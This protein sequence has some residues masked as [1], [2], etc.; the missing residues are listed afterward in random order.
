MLIASGFGLFAPLSFLEFLGIS[1]WRIEGKAYLGSFFIISAAVVV[2]HYGAIPVR[3]LWEKYLGVCT[4]WTLHAR[5]KS[6]TPDEQERLAR[7]L[8]ENTRTQKFSVEDGTVAGLVHAK[9]IYRAVSAADYYAVPF[10]IRPR[11]WKYLKKNP[12]LVGIKHSE[13]N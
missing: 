8:K 2:C 3:W 1:T 6:L 10:N 9:I 11:I 13:L 7:Y 12:H 5:L 4:V